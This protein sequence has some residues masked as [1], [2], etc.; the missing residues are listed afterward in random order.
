MFQT[1]ILAFFLSLV[2]FAKLNDGSQAQQQS[3][4]VTLQQSTTTFFSL[5]TNS[6]TSD[7]KEQD[8]TISLVI[9]TNVS[10]IFD[11]FTYTVSTTSKYNKAQLISVKTMAFTGTNVIGGKVQNI[12]KYTQLGC[13][14]GTNI[15]SPS[16]NVTGSTT[17]RLN[18][19]SIKSN[20]TSKASSSSTAI[21]TNVTAT[22][23][24]LTSTSSA[25]TKP[26][27]TPKNSTLTST[28]K[29]S[30]STTTLTS[31]SSLNANNILVTFNS[32]LILV[33]DLNSGSIIKSIDLPQD[34]DSFVLSETK[35]FIGLSSYHGIT[36]WNLNT[37]EQTC[38]YYIYEAVHDFVLIDNKYIAIGIQHSDN[39]IRVFNFMTCRMDFIFFTGYSSSYSLAKI[40]NNLLASYSDDGLVRVLDVNGLTLKANF[41][42]SFNYGTLYASDALLLLSEIKTIHVWSIGNFSIKK[43]ISNVSHFDKIFIYNDY[44]VSVSFQQNDV[45]VFSYSKS[46]LVKR[47]D[48][49]SGGHRNDIRNAV[50]FKSSG[51]LATI[52]YDQFIK[53][54]DLNKLTLKNSL[55]L[56]YIDQADFVSRLFAIGKSYLICYG[57]A[58]QSYL[59]DVENGALVYK[60]DTTTNFYSIFLSNVKSN[61]TFVYPTTTTSKVQTTTKPTTTTRK[62]PNNAIYNIITGSENSPIKFWS[63]SS[64][65][66]NFTLNHSF[67][68]DTPVDK[69]LVIEGKYLCSAH[70]NGMIKLWNLKN[71]SLIAVINNGTKGYSSGIDSIEY[72]GN[73]L[74]ASNRFIYENYIND[75]QYT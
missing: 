25:S 8:G 23:T 68:Q 5:I 45:F 9:V 2:F 21:K 53:I 36:V 48:P 56:G 14:N 69:L 57:T 37:S 17:S 63:S 22:S 41:S 55:D 67:S 6:T 34:F 24:K 61:F 12:T 38:S 18:T 50:F 40:S 52:G 28:T 10:Y 3:S 46:S 30:T 31:T 60:I 43:T 59:W 11:N 19:T 65:R 75:N 16:S 27:S 47:L 71:K 74:L 62:V 66:L 13:S 32:S 42:I 58:E 7:F 26:S 64:G 72:L 29:T 35:Y 4:F 44:I 20:T 49:L 15:V 39:P 51:I 73:G 70:K 1:K 33:F 54:W